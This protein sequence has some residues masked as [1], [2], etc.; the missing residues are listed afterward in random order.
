MP[1]EGDGGD[2]AARDKPVRRRRRVTPSAVTEAAWPLELTW[3][4][5]SQDKQHSC[6]AASTAVPPR[7]SYAGPWA[8]PGPAR[9]PKNEERYGRLSSHQNL[10]SFA[11]GPPAFLGGQHGRRGMAEG[12]GQWGGC[13][14]RQCWGS[15]CWACG[16]VCFDRKGLG[17]GGS[18]LTP[19]HPTSTCQGLPESP[20][21]GSVGKG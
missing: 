16:C 18:A 7:A 21:R 13:P 11:P 1:R 9:V 19:A 4:P 15:G 3:A 10:G 17:G 8:S 14:R 5:S 12:P 2:A 6:M 20:S